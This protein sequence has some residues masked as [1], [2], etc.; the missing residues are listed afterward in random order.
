MK[1]LLLKLKMIAD[2]KDF[3]QSVKQSNQQLKD[4]SVSAEKAG[5]SVEKSGKQAKSAGENYSH[6]A[7]NADKFKSALSEIADISG[8]VGRVVG[9]NLAAGTG[10][11]TTA[12][13]AFTVSILGAN[14]ELNTL[15]AQLD[16][17]K[18][19]LQ[20]WGVA[21]NDV[22][23][24]LEK[25]GD[26]FTDLNDK[27]GD[28]AAT[29]GGEAKEIFDRLNLSINEFIGL[30]ADKK[31]LA[32]AGAFDELGSDISLEEKTFL[33]EAMGNDASR[34]LPLLENNA[35]KFREL[36]K[37]AQSDGR[38][39]SD[40]QF[41]IL[42]DAT[43]K[44]KEIKSSAGAVKDQIGLIGAEIVNAFGDDL[45]GIFNEL[46]AGVQAF[47]NNF[48]VGNEIIRDSGQD[49]TGLL[50]DLW[51][52]TFETALTGWRDL[53]LTAQASYASISSY[54]EA[55]YHDTAS[56]YYGAQGAFADTMAEML[57]SGA[58]V[59]PQLASLGYKMT[60]SIVGGLADVAKGLDILSG[61]DG[62]S[63]L[64]QQLRGLA[65]SASQIEFTSDA[66]DRL[67]NS[68]KRAAIE[69]R[70]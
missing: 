10:I 58:E 21:G 36:E 44:L 65:N 47:A 46:N 57:A 33:L 70:Q 43:E 42:D 59:F 35:E 30:P 14:K 62:Q 66:T 37:L 34:L 53:P 13:A 61:G 40:D 8:K 48:V 64:E 9:S 12:T 50:Q 31:L 38:I 54:T 11:A 29:G 27:S 23:F 20:T 51:G 28:F 16:I 19:A 68:A 55:W 63:G 15:S 26:I 18:Q 69:H 41:K 32:L 2:N 17:S 1:E 56:A 49:T 22:G 60:A 45:I 39:F 3:N 6:A 5:Y 24:S 67:S 4:V 25:V 52:F 7:K